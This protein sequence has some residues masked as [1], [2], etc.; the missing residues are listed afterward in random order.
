[1]PAVMRAAAKAET[2]GVPAVVV[3]SRGFTGMGQIIARNLGVEGLPIA[4]YP[5][6]I[7]TDDD[8]TFDHKV[9]ET[10]VPGILTGLTRFGG[11]AVIAQDASPHELEGAER[12]SIVFAGTLD[13]VQEHF[14][15]NLWSDGLPIIPP[16]LD[17]VASFLRCTDREPSEVIGILPPEQREATVWSVAVN[18]VMAGCRPEYM[19]VLLAIVEA[20]ADPTFRLEDAGSTPGWEPLVVLS[21]AVAERLD[22]NSGAGVLKTGRQANTSVGRFVRL[23]MRNVAGLRIPPG[24]TDQAAIGYTFNCVLAE[25]D[26]AISELGWEPF[27][28]DEGF[29]LDDSSVSVQSVITISPPIYSGGR[30]AE[31][32]L[33]TIGTFFGRA[34]G[35]WV[36]L[37]LAHEGWHPLLVMSPSIARVMADDGLTK[38]D[39]R[40]WLYDNVRIPAAELEEHAP[41]VGHTNFNLE[42]LVAEGKAPEAYLESSDPLRL[43][44]QFVKPEWIGIV[45][46]GSAARNQSRAYVSNH[47]QGVRTSRRVRSP[48]AVPHL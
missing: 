28:M 36:F 18:G 31:D 17:R 13:E 32:H 14:M 30:R 4:E 34:I 26:Q 10:V 24:V 20:V 21:G 33:R 29:G 5:G 41:Q 25:N 46:A 12:E 47:G 27:R 40:A 6:V 42:R 8:M 19:P 35:P 1:M 2:G 38:D 39:I 44:P 11:E 16:T 7:L 15:R 48:A 43:V 23:F 45:V 9:R 37:A 22:F 3:G